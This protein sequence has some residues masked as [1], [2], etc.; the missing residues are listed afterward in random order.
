VTTGKKTDRR[1][2][3]RELKSITLV[4]RMEATLRAD[5]ERM[6]RTAD[7]TLGEFT[8]EL[9]HEG[10]ALSKQPKRAVS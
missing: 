3:K 5:I 9:L 8:R 1:P 2:P 7:K 10:L 4:L 6:A